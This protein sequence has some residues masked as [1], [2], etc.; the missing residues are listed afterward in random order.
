MLGR[1]TTHTAAL[2]YL[3]MPYASAKMTSTVKEWNIMML[4]M[5]FRVYPAE[6]IGLYDRVDRFKL[7]QSY[8]V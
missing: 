2:R 8:K 3:D 4:L 6:E 5:T 1:A 7:R